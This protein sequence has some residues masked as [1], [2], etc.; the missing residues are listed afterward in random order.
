MLILPN[1]FLFSAVTDVNA[2]VC[3]RPPQ[4]VPAKSGRNVSDARH[5]Q[6]CIILDFRFCDMIVHIRNTSRVS[7][8]F[9]TPSTFTLRSSWPALIYN[10]HKSAMMNPASCHFER[11]RKSVPP[12]LLKESWWKF[13]R[14]CV[15]N[16][17]CV[18]ISWWILHHESCTLYI[19]AFRDSGGAS[20]KSWQC[21]LSRDAGCPTTIEC[22]LVSQLIVVDEATS[23]LTVIN[24]NY[25]KVKQYNIVTHS[26]AIYDAIVW[27]GWLQCLQRHWCPTTIEYIFVSQIIVMNEANIGYNNKYIKVK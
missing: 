7:R 26:V 6:F 11:I 5:P 27:N 24:V 3:E 2:D 4:P 20:R 9:S 14:R 23:A 8:V 18:E 17:C 10:I 12:P 25:I 19:N 22:I 13:H 16:Q 15:M 1:W 21:R